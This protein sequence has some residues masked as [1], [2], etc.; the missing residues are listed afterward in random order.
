MSEYGEK[1][2]SSY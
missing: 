2:Y 1:E